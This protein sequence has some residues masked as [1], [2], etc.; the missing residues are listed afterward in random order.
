LGL[1]SM[2]CR[3]LV[4]AAL[5]RV[6][7]CLVASPLPAPPASVL[8]LPL[9]AS[10]RLH[11]AFPLPASDRRA[12]CRPGSALQVHMSLQRTGEK[13]VPRRDPGT[14]LEH[15]TR[16]CSTRYGAMAYRVVQSAAPSHAAESLV[17]ASTAHD[18][19]Q[20]MSERM[21]R[22]RG[23]ARSESAMDVIFVHG[24]GDPLSPPTQGSSVGTPA[25]PSFPVPH[26]SKS[27]LPCPTSRPPFPF[28]PPPPACLARLTAAAGLRR[29]R[30]QQLPAA[31][32]GT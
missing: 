2:W 32:R 21:L 14:P 29:Y 20:Q 8:A 3:S 31:F 9:R 18:M 12:A 25:F 10:G 5:L 28:P 16:R 6:T 4:L 17:C 30:R 7:M 11:G 13:S 27:F 22:D 1:S 19:A 24:L 26:P 23:Q 15:I